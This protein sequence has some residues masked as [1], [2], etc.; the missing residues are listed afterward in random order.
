MDI[1]AFLLDNDYVLYAPY[2]AE[3]FSESDEPI[4]I[5]WWDGIDT[6]GVTSGILPST[7]NGRTK[8][9]S[10]NDN[11][12]SKNPTYVMIPKEIKFCD[13]DDP[14]CG[15]G[16]GSGG[17]GIGGGGSYPTSPRSIDCRVLRDDDIMELRMPEFRLRG[18]TRGG[19]HRI[20]ST[21]G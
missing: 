12:A 6:T 9:I 5:S 11:Y 8:I 20:Y 17:G 10:V 3:N 2:Y 15:G 19:L 13:I 16:G 21:C 7:S 1:E 14:T 4:T 18:N